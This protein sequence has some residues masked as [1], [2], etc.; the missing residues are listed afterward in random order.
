MDP[1]T[2]TIWGVADIAR[3]RG[4]SK[5]QA[6]NNMKQHPLVPD[7]VAG[8]GKRYWKPERIKEWAKDLPRAG[9]YQRTRKKHSQK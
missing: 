2:E 1:V 5:V 7:Y 8:D 6:S 3:Y 4:V 9:G